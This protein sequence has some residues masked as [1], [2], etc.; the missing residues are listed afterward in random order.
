MNK[1]QISKKGP[2]KFGDFNKVMRFMKTLNDYEFNV[3]SRLVE[4]VKII[5]TIRK[6]YHVSKEEFCKEMK[7]KPS[8]Y[9]G[10]IKGYRNY[11][12][13]DMVMINMLHAKKEKEWID[14]NEPI[15]VAK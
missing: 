5:N 8:E 13:K 15:Q 10:F 3:L 4:F 7:I 11:D 14:K 2:V 9:N 6:K 1:R 12:L